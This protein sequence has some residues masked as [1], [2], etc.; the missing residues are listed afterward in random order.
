MSNAI[1]IYNRRSAQ[2]ECLLFAHQFQLMHITIYAQ[3][4]FVQFT[5]DDIAAIAIFQEVRQQQIVGGKSEACGGAYFMTR[6][7]DDRLLLLLCLSHFNSMLEWF[8]RPILVEN[9][10]ATIFHWDQ[11]MHQFRQLK[12][13]QNYPLINETFDLFDSGEWIEPLAY[14][15]LFDAIDIIAIDRPATNPLLCKHTD[16]L[17]QNRIINGFTR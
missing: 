5:I 11:T 9:D 2:C 13:S 1:A 17:L 15:D 8:T 4:V 6:A 14:F 16:I 3:R 10:C 12:C 7:F